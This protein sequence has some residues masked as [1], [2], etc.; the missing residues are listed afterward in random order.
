MTL[1]LILS[2]CFAACTIVT[3]INV[4]RIVMDKTVQGVSVVPVVVFVITNLFQVVYFAQLGE[5]WN[6]AGS[7]GMASGNSVWIILHCLY[8]REQK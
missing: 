4:Y 5:W 1:S 7:A 2:Y 8:R 6:V 3:W